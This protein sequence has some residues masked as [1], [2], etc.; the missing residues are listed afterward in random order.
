MFT[1]KLTG[2]SVH[3]TSF[4]R[5]IRR[6]AEVA[7]RF[8]L[9]SAGH[10]DNIPPELTV[11][12]GAKR[13]VVI[14]GAGLSGLCA[15]YLLRQAGIGITLLEA[16]DRPGGRV[17]TLREGFADGLHADAGAARIS[18]FHFRTLAWIKQFGLGLESMYPDTGYLVSERNGHAVCGIDA[19]C[20]SSHDI[21]HILVSQ[22]SWD[23]Q[24]SAL[25]SMQ[26]LFRNS[27]I[28]PTW[29]RVKGGTDCLPRAFADR[30]EGSIRYGVAVTKIKSCAKWVDVHFQTDGTNQYL[31]A[32]FA[33]CAL[34]CTALQTIRMS[35]EL[36]SDKR[37]ILDRSRNESAT[38]V[39]LQLRDRA[40]L[41]A[42]WSGYG[43][44]PDKWEIWQSAST[45]SRRCLLT[46]YVQGEAA[47]P[48][49]TLA[50]DA[51]IDRVKSR[52][53]GLFPGIRGNVETAAQFCWDEDPWTRGAQHIG[54]LPIEVASRAEGRTHFAGAH[55]SASGWMDGALESGYRVAIE[56]LRKV[57]DR[58]FVGGSK[59]NQL[60]L[61]RAES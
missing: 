26:P 10:C 34:P 30:L 47:V 23:T 58:G 15:A 42:R 31:R 51:R 25:S 27:L 20:L 53:E 13:H 36:P 1:D 29:Y 39:F 22:L 4:A 43:V 6:A 2:T 60:D 33:V 61:I 19:A 55:T 14:V 52:L 24:W 16:R 3:T 41:P 38:R 21:H 49:A 50:P 17:F 45:T 7:R 56:I 46:I 48:F 5:T 35:P 18:D 32:D 44:T 8:K 9:R 11:A 57:R 59:G 37:W 40:E 54:E 12:A 28:K